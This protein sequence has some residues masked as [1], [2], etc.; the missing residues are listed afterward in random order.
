MRG[1]VSLYASRHSERA[2]PACIREARCFVTEFTSVPGARR[3]HAS[4]FTLC[5]M[6]GYIYGGGS[7]MA[8]RRLGRWPMKVPIV[9]MKDSGR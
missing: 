7:R 6:N 8:K 4:D 3:P 5:F 2:K 1:K 9:V